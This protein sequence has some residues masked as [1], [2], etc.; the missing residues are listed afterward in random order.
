LRLHSTLVRA[1]SSKDND[2]M[3]FYDEVGTSHIVA[4]SSWRWSTNSN[5][6]G[7]EIEVESVKLPKN[8]C[9]DLALGIGVWKIKSRH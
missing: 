1:Q 8:P 3:D 9:Q 4:Q 5:I 7:P 2:R 6:A